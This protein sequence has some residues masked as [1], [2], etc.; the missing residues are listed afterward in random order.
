MKKFCILFIVISF[1][2]VSFLFTRHDKVYKVS[3]VISPVQ[4]EFSNNKNLT[5]KDFDC[6]DAAY[7]HKN[8]LLAKKL[9]I[10][11]KEAFILGNFGKYWAMNLLQGRFV[12]LE[13]NS[14]LVYL[15]FNYDEK[16]RYSGYCLEEG[17]PC[18]SEC[19]EKRLKDIRTTKYVVL[20]TENENVYELDA[21]E[22]KNIQKFLVI[23][24]FHIPKDMIKKSTK[25]ISDDPV[26][27]LKSGK[28][29]VF[30][31]DFTTKLK[32]D[33]GCSTEICREI[34]SG[35]NNSKETIDVA[36]YGYS[37]TPEIE[38]AL[39]AAQKRGVKV[40]LV[41]DEDANRK[42]IYPDTDIIKKLISDINSDANTDEA[43]SI[44]HNKF[45]IF[46][47][48]IL[49][50]GSANLS[51][52]D[53]SGFNS[54]SAV[55]IESP[56]IAQIYKQEFDEMYSGKFHNKKKQIKNKAV[57]ISGTDIKIY[58]SPK[59]KCIENAIIPLIN[60]AQKYIY[61]PTFVLTDKKVMA[62]LIAA[63]Q[64]GVDI[65]I[66]MDALNASVQH[67][68]HKE[69][70]AGGI[71]VKTENYAG[72]MHS[73]SMIIDDEYT[74]IGSMNFSYSGEN[75]N[76]ENLLVI[77]NSEITKAYKKFFLYQWNKIDNKWLKY[78]ARA[79]GKD[80]IGSCSDGLDNDY[81]GLTDMEDPAC[82]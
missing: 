37:S 79:E 17:K 61:I 82:R 68:K 24:K 63:K 74:I 73:K 50:T 49:I 48:K 59:D 8:K 32:P 39:I 65:K 11:E 53:M 30:F 54:N 43:N 1:L 72:K 55:V 66:I 60:N 67:S 6:F 77:K 4:I 3:G 10:S 76:D 52:T 16:F 23:K 40:R 34:L 18:C 13:G 25:I 47:N 81:D 75:K 12:Y 57:N 5:L 62:A 28:I 42:N 58:F 64:R 14:D 21:P 71:E 44:M 45:Y 7:T 31:T 38:K 41:Y 29:K 51:H 9:N 22:I 27:N 26:K 70:R 78:N 15:K 69:L 46:D 36:I 56:E 80:S 20:D 33:R 35:I 2:T 19:L